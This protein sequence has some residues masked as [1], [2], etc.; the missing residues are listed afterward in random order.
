M[1]RLFSLL[2]LAALLSQGSLAMAAGDELR[3]ILGGVH[4]KY[5]DLPGLTISY[6]REVITRSMSMLGNQVRGD[7]ASGIIYFK[8]PYFLRL[9]QEEPKSEILTTNGET[10]WWYIPEQKRVYEYPSQKYGQ[11]MRILSDI[12]R[13]LA[14]VEENFKVRLLDKSPQGEHLIELVPDPPWQQIEK[15]VVYVTKNDEIRAVDIHNQMGSMTRFTL[16]DMQA[17][18]S[19]PE[20][21]FDFVVPQGVEVVHEDG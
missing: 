7:T 1:L 15:I 13:G 8:P 4:K 3:E 6:S 21:F 9:E 16:K 2:Q 14:R 20:A 17:R 10:L 12:L 19:F 18:E 5:G 11:E